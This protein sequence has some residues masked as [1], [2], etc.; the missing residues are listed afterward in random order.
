ME[1]RE[2]LFARVSLI[3]KLAITEKAVRLNRSK[4]EVLE[5]ILNSWRRDREFSLTKKEDRN[6]SLELNRKKAKE[7]RDKRKIRRAKKHQ[8]PDK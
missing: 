8:R 4:N 2:P 6:T 1:S 3:N 5:E 7:L